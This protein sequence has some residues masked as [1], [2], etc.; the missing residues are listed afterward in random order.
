MQ[1]SCKY[2]IIQFQIANHQEQCHVQYVIYSVSCTVC[3]ARTYSVTYTLSTVLTVSLR[4]VTNMILTVS[5][6][7]SHV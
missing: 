1:E 3:H 6:T 2:N 5:C 4:H 7:R